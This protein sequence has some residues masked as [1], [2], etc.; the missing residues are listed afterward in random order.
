MQCTQ[1]ISQNKKNILEFYLSFDETFASINRSSYLF[2][3]FYGFLFYEFP[4]YEFP[5]YEFPF[6]E[7]FKRKHF[8]PLKI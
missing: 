7:Y 2:F 8:T 1:C 3:P 4:F 6:Y 5:F